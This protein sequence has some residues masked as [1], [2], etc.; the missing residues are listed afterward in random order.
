MENEKIKISKKSF[1]VV[2]DLRNDAD[3]ACT[4]ECLSGGSASGY[5]LC[6]TGTGAQQF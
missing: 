5:A 3:P 4:G 6:D 1:G 2:F